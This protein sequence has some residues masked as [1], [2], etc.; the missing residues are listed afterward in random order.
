[1]REIVTD[2]LRLLLFLGLPITVLL[3]FLAE[4]VVSI[5]FERGLFDETS[6]QNVAT[7]LSYFS[8]GLIALM[9]LEVISRTFYSLSDTWTPV[10]A[11]GLQVVMMAVLSLWLGLI[12]FPNWAGCLWLGWRWG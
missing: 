6:T 3:I 4:P 9:M 12:L 7:V 5:L 2:S 10:L 11:G 8:L 1:M